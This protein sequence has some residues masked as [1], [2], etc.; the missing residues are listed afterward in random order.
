MR[1]MKTIV[2]KSTQIDMIP[3]TSTVNSE[4]FCPGLELC[5]LSRQGQYGLHQWDDLQGGVVRIG[6]DE[7]T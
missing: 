4:Q 5:P 3:I 1:Q 7:D 6:I 2:D